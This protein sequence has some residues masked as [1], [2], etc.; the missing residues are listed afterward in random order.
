MLHRHDPGFATEGDLS[1]SRN[2][3]R[4][5]PMA[6]LLTEAYAAAVHHAQYLHPDPHPGDFFHYV[7][8]NHLH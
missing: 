8:L 1:C 7:F 6:E 3:A 4:A 5:E 2:K